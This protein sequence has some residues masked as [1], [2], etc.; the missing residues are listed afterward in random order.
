LEG[1]NVE[2][3]G[4]L[5][6]WQGNLFSDSCEN[7]IKKLDYQEKKTRI[8]HR[9]MVADVPLR[10]S[11]LLRPFFSPSGVT[12]FEFS[13]TNK[14][15]KEEVDGY[16]KKIK[17][18]ISGYILLRN[19][20]VNDEL[21][22]YGEGKNVFYWDNRTIEFLSSKILLYNLWSLYG[23]TTEKVI[24]NNMSYMRCIERNTIDEVFQI[25]LAILSHHPT[26][27]FGA[28]ELRKAIDYIKNDI[29]NVACIAPS[30]I[31]LLILTRSL[32][33]KDLFN[34]FDS[35]LK[36]FSTDE[37]AFTSGRKPI[38]DFYTSPF[39]FKLNLSE[40]LDFF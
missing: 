35:L 17:G 32:P 16:N 29:L 2:T 24:E 15:G 7:F 10:S 31:K 19:S 30:Q 18:N 21:I 26:K 38:M 34:Q 5:I 40:D 11:E 3:D 27:T 36:D 4:E 13:T 23:K 9:D 37:I 20:K 25:R 14:H 1:N 6:N 33:R 39:S 28:N 8:S 12:V 22:D